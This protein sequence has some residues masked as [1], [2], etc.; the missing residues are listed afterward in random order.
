MSELKNN[1]SEVIDEILI[2]IN[3]LL[4][5]GTSLSYGVIN[6]QSRDLIGSDEKYIDHTLVLFD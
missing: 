2:P 6:D 1:Q 3:R 4:F 5:I